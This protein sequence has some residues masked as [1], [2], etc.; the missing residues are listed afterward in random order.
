M[1]LF[2]SVISNQTAETIGGTVNN[3]KEML[4][5]DPKCEFLIAVLIPNRDTLVSRMEDRVKNGFSRYPIADRCL[6]G[7]PNV[8]VKFCATLVEES[9][10]GQLINMLLDVMFTRKRAVGHRMMNPEADVYLRNFWRHCQRNGAEVTALVLLV[11]SVFLSQTK[12]GR[13]FI[14]VCYLPALMIL[15]S[16]TNVVVAMLAAIGYVPVIASKYDHASVNTALVSIPVVVGLF[17]GVL[18]HI[19]LLCVCAFFIMAVPIF[20]YMLVTSRAIY[21]EVRVIVQYLVSVSIMLSILWTATEQS[22]DILGGVLV[23]TLLGCVPVGSQMFEMWILN[24]LGGYL[25]TRETLIMHGVPQAWVPHTILGLLFLSVICYLA[26]R[27][28]LGAGGLAKVSNEDQVRRLFLCLYNGWC[29]PKFGRIVWNIMEMRGFKTVADT[30]GTLALGLKI[31]EFFYAPDLFAASIL[32]FVICHLMDIPSD[33]RLCYDAGFEVTFAPEFFKDDNSA[34]WLDVAGL[35]ALRDSVVWLISETTSGIGL[36]CTYANSVYILS[37]E[38]VFTNEKMKAIW[39]SGASHEITKY[40]PMCLNAAKDAVVAALVQ[41]DGCGKLFNGMSIR[42]PS[43]LNGNFVAVQPDGFVNVFK[44]IEREIN[45]VNRIP[46]C[47]TFGDSGSPV[48]EVKSDGNI[49]DLVG[50]IS[51]GGADGR[52]VWMTTVKDTMETAAQARKHG[53]G[54]GFGRVPTPPANVPPTTS[55]STPLADVVTRLGN[56]KIG[57]MLTAAEGLLASEGKG[58]AELAA[59]KEEFSR[60]FEFGKHANA[61][62]KKITS[63]AEFNKARGWMKSMNNSVKAMCT[64]IAEN[65]GDSEMGVSAIAEALKKF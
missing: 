50:H 55:A 20:W 15:F 34:P 45:G 57:D 22:R 21:V 44:T 47:A 52:S 37:A 25:G 8:G 53:A 23:D 35:S 11:V 16:Y 28:S 56:A 24:T 13:G 48:F 38:H 41:I 33:Q 30:S 9:R 12:K 29:L 5:G 14:Y 31:M 7:D 18:E 3:L 46:I 61:E 51:C 32:F 36:A 54:L 62:A 59:A 4:T 65:V 26:I 10:Y 58:H 49:V 17:A 6:S 40:A 2:Q 19:W 42:P 43:S 64:I 39:P 1:F 60:A 27:A 63:I